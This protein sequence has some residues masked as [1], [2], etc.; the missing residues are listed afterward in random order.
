MTTGCTHTH[1]GDLLASGSH[2][3]G[4]PEHRQYV[5]RR[6]GCAGHFP[7]VTVS[8]G[9]FESTHD[10][11][12]VR[13]RLE[14]VRRDDDRRA[15]VAGNVGDAAGIVVASP[16]KRREFEVDGRHGVV[17]ERGFERVE[18]ARGV[19]GL[20]TLPRRPVRDEYREVAVVGVQ[21]CQRLVGEIHP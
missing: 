7:H 19:G 6:L 13:R 12:A 11:V 14:V 18:A 10:V 2:F 20:A 15:A 3:A 8:T 21:L 5:V 17:F 16:R 4:R 1:R 9:P